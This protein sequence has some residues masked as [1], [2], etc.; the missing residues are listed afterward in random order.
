MISISLLKSKKPQTK[1]KSRNSI[2]CI[3][4]SCVT[5]AVTFMIPYGLLNGVSLSWCSLIGR[6]IKRH[7]LWLINAESVIKEIHFNLQGERGAG[8]ERQAGEICWGHCWH[9]IIC[10]AGMRGLYGVSPRQRVGQAEPG[11]APKSPARFFH[12]CHMANPE[13]VSQLEDNRNQCSSSHLLLHLMLLITLMDCVAIK[14]TRG[15]H[16]PG[17]H[18]PGG[19][20]FLQ[21]V[22]EARSEMQTTSEWSTHVEVWAVPSLRDGAVPPPGTKEPPQKRRILT[23]SFYHCWESRK[24]SLFLLKQA[25]LSH[26]HPILQSL[27][28]AGFF[29]PPRKAFPAHPMPRPCLPLFPPTPHTLKSH[30]GKQVIRLQ[31]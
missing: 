23:C 15:G 25:F 7:D 28:L 1:A 22:K 12:Q 3:V 19:L 6:L 29:Q 13:L 21:D 30:Q 4:H 8:G 31:D 24:Q 20:F 10:K 11:L 9:A 27:S 14:K 16:Q 5:P 26:I 2:S 18:Q 17:G